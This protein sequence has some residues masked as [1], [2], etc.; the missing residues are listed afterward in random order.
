MNQAVL[1]NVIKHGDIKLATKE[2]TRS[3]LVSERNYHASKSF[4][5]KVM[6]NKPFCLGLSIL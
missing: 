2:R 5:K 4:L 1:E 6:T 3:Y